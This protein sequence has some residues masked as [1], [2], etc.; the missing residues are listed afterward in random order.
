MEARGPGSP[1]KGRSPVR[2]P[3]K[4]R[5]GWPLAESLRRRLARTGLEPVQAPRAR[6]GV[7]IS[8]I[9]CTYNEAGRIRQIL[10]AVRR[11]RAL[12]EVIV[13]NDGSTDGTEAVLQECRDILV[14]SYAPNRGKAYA[15]SRGIDV[16][17]GDYVMTLDADLAGVTAADIQA[18]ADPVLRG[19]ADVSISL[20]RNSLWPYGASVLISCQASGSYRPR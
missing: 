9:V 16:A 1:D 5:E 3:E 20:R 18:L 10:D 17:T 11:H 13:V 4:Q 12:A 7:R 6:P 14:V 2:A 15:L 8:C 19:E